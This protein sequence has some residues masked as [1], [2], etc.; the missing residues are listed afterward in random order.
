MICKV[1]CIKNI[2]NEIVYIGITSYSIKK[3]FSEHKCA[4]KLDDTFYVEL[5]QDNLS[6][7]QARNTERELIARYDLIDKGL[8]RSPG[9]TSGGIMLHTEEN[10]KL[11]RELK[12]GKKVSAIHL[13]SIRKACAKRRGKKMTKETVDK[14]V[15][16]TSKRV[17]CVETNT[18]YLNCVAAARALNCTAGRIASCCRGEHKKH[19]NYTFQYIEHGDERERLVS[20]C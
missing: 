20:D 9:V 2:D 12:L 4:K 11:F 1:Y 5:I 13:E 14:V 7:E 8:N 15:W 16:S 10:K 17:F 19:K 3:R 18:V 6:L